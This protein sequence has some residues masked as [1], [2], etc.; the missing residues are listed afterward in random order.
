MLEAYLRQH[1]LRQKTELTYYSPLPRAFSIESVSEL[2]AP[3]LEERGV[4]TE[5]F[6]NLEAVNEPKRTMHSMEGQEVPF[7]LLVIVPPHRG[8]QI[9]ERSALTDAQGWLPTDRNTLEVKGQGRA[10]ALGDV[11]DLPVSKSGS[12]AHFEAGVVAERITAS[13]RGRAV[14]PREGFYD[15]RVMRFMETGHAQATRIE[16]DYEHPPVPP[17]PGWF[18]HM[19]K[20]LFN[21]AYWYL[22]P[23]AR[24]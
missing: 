22:V 15:G 6:F 18:Y 9:A 5:I 14:H 4:K 24:V 19:E 21:R 20:A 8:A 10:Y 3:L 13:I 12:A 11:T 23:P 7:D 17:K 16:F 1:G 2:A